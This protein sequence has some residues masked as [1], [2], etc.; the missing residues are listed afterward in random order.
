MKWPGTRRSSGG[1]PAAGFVRAWRTIAAGLAPAARLPL[2]AL[3]TLAAPAAARAGDPEVLPRSIYVPIR[4]Q[5]A[6]CL[7]EV[8]IR[9]EAGEVRAVAPGR[10]VSQF[11]FHDRREGSHPAW[12][13]LTIEGRIQPPGEPVGPAAGPAPPPGRFRTGIVITPASIYVGGKRFDLGTAARLDRFRRRADLRIP[14]RTLR[15]RPPGG[16]GAL[17]RAAGRPPEPPAGS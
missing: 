14:E 9:T 2:V 6:P 17:V 12:E 13:R 11:T 8:V 5:P 16:C 15:L 7:R 1:S 10:L 3:L 4:F